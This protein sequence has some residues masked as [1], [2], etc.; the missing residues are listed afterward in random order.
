MSAGRNLSIAPRY[1]RGCGAAV[2]QVA[3]T[4]GPHGC[5]R[6]KSVT[7]MPPWRRQMFTF[8]ADPELGS[9][10]VQ[11]EPDATGLADA[12]G[13]VAAEATRDRKRHGTTMLFAAL[14][15]A[16]GIVADR[17]CKPSRLR[18]SP[19]RHKTVARAHPR[20]MASCATSEGIHA[21]AKTPPT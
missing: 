18:R 8:S 11:A 14:E 21:H 12:T 1:R 17:C 13:G 10:Q 2:S 15:V 4:T 7:V 19:R 9:S 3:V 16:K 5:A 20:K 6:P